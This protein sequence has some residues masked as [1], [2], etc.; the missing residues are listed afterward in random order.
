MHSPEELLLRQ[1]QQE[2]SRGRG[3]RS[4]VMLEGRGGRGRLPA[5]RRLEGSRVNI[6]STCADLKLDAWHHDHTNTA[7]LT[8]LRNGSL[9]G[10]TLMYQRH[11]YFC[12]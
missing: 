7:W 9:E 3:R 6:A 4:C 12:H 11:H 10:D 1:L 2:S 5:P 8:S